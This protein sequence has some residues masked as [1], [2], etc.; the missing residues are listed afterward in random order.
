M[1]WL[2]PEELTWEGKVEELAHAGIN[3]ADSFFAVAGLRYG[4]SLQDVLRIY[5]GPGN[6]VANKTYEYH[7]YGDVNI[8]VRPHT[9]RVAVV[10][11][12]RNRSVLGN[13]L[14][15]RIGDPKLAFLGEAENH[16]RQVLGPPAEAVGGSLHYRFGS[17]DGAHGEV[18]FDCY[19]FDGTRC[20]MILVYWFD[21]ETSLD[22]TSRAE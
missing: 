18:Q 17:R 3:S 22:G 9:G 15:N 6:V 4:D 20:G 8:G 14:R 19:P 21:G 2:R 5:G 1:L 16:I 7:G 12:E 13:D 11:V 10:R